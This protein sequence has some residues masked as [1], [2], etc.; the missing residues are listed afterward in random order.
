MRARRLL[1]SASIAAALIA[2]QS[3]A[4]AEPMDPALERLVLNPGCHQQPTTGKASNVGVW[5]PA[6]GAGVDGRCI[7]DD[8]AFKR[9]VNQYGAALAPTAMHSARTTGYGGFELS[10]E[11]SFTSLDDGADYMQEGTRGSIDPSTNKRSIRNN[12]PDPI[13]QV[14]YLKARKGFPFGFEIAALIGTMSNT[15]FTILGSD[16]RL[17][18]LEGFRQGALGVLPDIAVGGGVRTVTGSPQLQ[19]TTAAFDTQISKPLPIADA[20]VLTPYVGYQYLWIF[21]DSGLIDTTPNTDP[22]GLCGYQ[23]PNVPGTPG[24]SD[25]YDGQPVCEGGTPLDFNNT[26]VFDAVRLQRQRIIVGANYRF[27]MLMVGLQYLTD[28][29]DPASA[30]DDEDLE[31]IPSQYTISVQLGAMF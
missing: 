17:S 24:A 30:N 27:E 14:Y 29:K 12:G 11:G 15:S 20:S 2:S 22:V 28:L 6:G 16:V 8:V 23:G 7:A 25:P 13:A 19:L 21:G 1:A 26:F 4:N 18:L 10:L 3:E 31:G 9:L 5:N